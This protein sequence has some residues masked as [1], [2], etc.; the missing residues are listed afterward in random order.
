MKFE[1]IIC[2]KMEKENEFF[3]HIADNDLDK[4]ILTTV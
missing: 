1:F 3:H 4:K 2:K